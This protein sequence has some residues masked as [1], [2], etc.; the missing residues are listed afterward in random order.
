MWGVMD[1]YHNDD[2]VWGTTLDSLMEWLTMHPKSELY[3][4]N[5][6]FDGNFLISYLL[7]NG[8]GYVHKKKE[9]K[10]HTFTALIADTGAF[11]SMDLAIKNENNRVTFYDSAKIIPNTSVEGMASAFGLGETK[12]KIDYHKERPVGY[13]P[14][15]IEIDYMRRDLAIPCGALRFFFDQGMDKMTLAGNALQTYKNIIGKN[16][17][18][19]WFPQLDFDVD[20]YCRQS[21]KGAFTWVNPKYKNLDLGEGIAVDNNSIYPYVM[22]TKLLPYGFPVAF[23]GEYQQDDEYP[24]YITT[25]RCSFELKEGFIPTIQIKGGR[26]V[27][28]EYLVDSDD[29]EVTLVMTSVDI[30]LFFDHYD[31]YNPQYLGG[32]KFKGSTHLFKEYVDRFAKMKID[33]DKSGNM[34]LRTLAKLLLNALY[35]RFGMNPLKSSKYP[36]GLNDDGVVVYKKTDDKISKSLFVPTASFITA[37]A[38]DLDIRTGQSFYDRALYSDTDSWKILGLEPVDIDI[39]ATRL[40]AWKD[41]GHFN[42]IRILGQKCYI[43]KLQATDNEMDKYQEKKPDLACHINREKHEILSVTC[44]GLPDK[45][46]SQVTWENFQYEMEY[47]GKLTQKVV[48]GGVMLEETTYRINKR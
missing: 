47:S 45:C 31:V 8:Y 44:A 13:Q 30:K 21:Y 22:S 43:M 18:D 11:Y 35:G 17:F 37:Y 23:S 24:L 26:F 14:D 33:A 12:G 7:R 46:H 25:I 28:T 19:Y 27:E 5:L 20:F 32:Y 36:L 3:F 48:A 34:A 15:E 1:I 39:D 42:E 6:R 38:R 29:E 16:K 40:G 10:K 41:E 4:H 9:L 2:F